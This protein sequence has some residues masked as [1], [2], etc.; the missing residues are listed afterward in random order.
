MLSKLLLVLQ[1]ILSIAR[2][3]KSHKQKNFHEI[4]VIFGHHIHF[5]EH[6]TIY[7]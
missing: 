1:I 4:Y 7:S 3:L 5:I 2:S 6:T